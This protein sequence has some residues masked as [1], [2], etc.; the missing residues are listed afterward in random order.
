MVFFGA[1]ALALAT[2]AVPVFLMI[3]GALLLARGA[4]RRHRVVGLAAALLGLALAGTVVLA[5]ATT[6]V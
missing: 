5:I 2:H 4:E 1:V 6:V 3:G